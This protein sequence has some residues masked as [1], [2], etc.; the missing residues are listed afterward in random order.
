MKTGA[1]AVFVKTPGFSP[2]KS[3]LSKTIGEEKAEMFYLLSVSATKALIEQY[4]QAYNI[5]PYWAVAEQGASHYWKDF[6]IITQEG[7]T[8]GHRLSSVYNRLLKKHKFVFLIGADSPMISI[9]ILKEAISQVKNSFV[10]GRA[11]D[12]GFYLFGGEKKISEDIWVSIPYS[13][14]KTA[15][16]LHEKIR[17]LGSIYELPPLLDIDTFSDLRKMYSDYKE[18]N[19][20]LPE[21]RKLLLWMKTILFSFYFLIYF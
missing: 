21:Q 3:R 17:V 12:G 2:V 19:K 20:L 1:I 7:G 11:L 16:K 13:H 18:Q 9:A 5:I 8:L 10:L 4:T 6:Q 14:S 15:E